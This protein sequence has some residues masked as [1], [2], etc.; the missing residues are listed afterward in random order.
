MLARNGEAESTARLPGGDTEQTSLGLVDA[1]VE[2]DPIKSQRVVDIAQARTVG[3]QRRHFTRQALQHGEI[4][5]GDTDG[6]R[7]FDR[8]AIFESD[9]GDPRVWEAVEPVAQARKQRRAILDVPFLQRDEHI[10]IA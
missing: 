5:A 10:A 8:W 6:D 9:D 7:G 2:I 3:H 1:D 4:G